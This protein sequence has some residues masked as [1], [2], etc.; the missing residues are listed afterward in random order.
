MRQ[1]FIQNDLPTPLSFEI[2]SIIGNTYFIRLSRPPAG[3]TSKQWDRVL[4]TAVIPQ[5]G[6]CRVD[7]PDGVIQLTIDNKAGMA[8]ALDRSRTTDG[9]KIFYRFSPAKTQEGRN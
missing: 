4:K 7:L 1:W 5:K 6:E 8:I 3:L 9:Q 2:T